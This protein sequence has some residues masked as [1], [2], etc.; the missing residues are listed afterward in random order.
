MK[1]NIE[2]TVWERRDRLG[3]LAEIMETANGGMLKTKIMYKVNLSFSQVKEYLRFLTE[4][5]FLKIR[6][7][8]KKKI[9]ETTPKGCQY[10]ESYIEMTKLL[11]KERPI[12]TPILSSSAF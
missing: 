1:S 7:E 8:N 5:G 9:Y 12:E 11:T 4:T 2:Q 10:I 6:L 3:I